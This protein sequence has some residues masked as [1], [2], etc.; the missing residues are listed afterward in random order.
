MEFKLDITENF[1]LEG[2][3]ATNEVLNGFKGGNFLNLPEFL[4]DDEEQGV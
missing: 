3:L 1:I 2:R 4:R